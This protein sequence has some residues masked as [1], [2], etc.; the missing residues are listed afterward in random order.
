LTADTLLHPGTPVTNELRSRFQIAAGRLYG[1]DP[2]FAARLAAFYPLFGLRWVLI[3]L[4]EFH[5]ERWRRRVL[6]GVSEGWSEAKSRQ[7]DAARAMLDGSRML[8]RLE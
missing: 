4:N 5:P 3:L 8:G 1:R 6:A 2:D 7:L